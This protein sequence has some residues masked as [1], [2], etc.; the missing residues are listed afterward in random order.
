M[1]AVL[2]TNLIL[3]A[4]LWFG[5]P[6]VLLDQVRAGHVTLFTS[7][8]LLVELRDV[9]GRRK[10]ARKLAAFGFTPDQLVAE[11]LTL[12]TA[13]QAQPLPAAVCLDPDDDAV[14]ACAV[15]ANAD[16]IVSGDRHLLALGSYQGIPILTAAAVLAR[17]PPP[18]P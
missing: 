10:F 12:A 3:S 1:R 9:L 6:R 18:S 13:V 17:L 4:F 5:T 14:L 16:I 15:A 7:A 8:E 11:Y 2:D